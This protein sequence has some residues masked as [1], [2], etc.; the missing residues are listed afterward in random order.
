MYDVLVEASFGYVLSRQKVA[1][2]KADPTSIMRVSNLVRRQFREPDANAGEGGEL[3]L[4]AFLEG[5]LGAPK[6]LSKMELKTSPNHYVNGAD[7]I[8]LLRGDDGYFQLIFGESKMYGDGNGRRGSGIKRAI[9]NAFKS[10]EELRSSA[11]RSDTWLVESELMKETL[12]GEAIDF[13]ASVLIPDATDDSVKKINAFGVFIGYEVDVDCVD[14]ARL[15][16][17]EIEAKLRSLAEV[18]IKS[19]AVD[20]G[21]AITRNGLD[22]YPFHFYAIPFA[23]RTIKGEREGID[24]VRL[25]LAKVLRTGST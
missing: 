15:K 8:H 13:L 5:H 6:L 3:L 21:V 1:A 7:G 23:T 4:Y 10:I 2:F 18:E 22:G 14:F 19:H 17:A 16:I 11:F 20:I 9:T 24:R 12:D 25:D